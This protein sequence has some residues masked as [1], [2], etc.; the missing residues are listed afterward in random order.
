MTNTNNG[1]CVELIE[2]L[3]Y[4]YDYDI[5]RCEKTDDDTVVTYEQ[6]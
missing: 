1:E 6:Y 5:N 4:A 2:I 3:V